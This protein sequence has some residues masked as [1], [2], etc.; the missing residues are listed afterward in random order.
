MIIYETA[1][2]KPLIYSTA[3]EI[4]RGKI[5]TPCFPLVR[6]KSSDANDPKITLFSQQWWGFCLFVLVLNRYSYVCLGLSCSLHLGTDF[7]KSL[8]FGLHVFKV[9]VMT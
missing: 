4:L 7:L 3:S 6:T 9:Q 1:K 2:S 8:I 5:Y